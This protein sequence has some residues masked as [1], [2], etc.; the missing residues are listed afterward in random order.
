MAVLAMGAGAYAG[1][2]QGSFCH[3][4]I[5]NAVTTDV[6]HETFRA[7]ETALITVSGDGDTDLDLY[8]YDEN[9]Y[10][11]ASD[12]DLTDQCVVSFTPLWTGSFTIK[13]RNLGSVWNA[14][15]VCM[16]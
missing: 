14:Y 11:I 13:V 9:G 6:Y 2:R 15:T 5:V 4:D 1:P 10:L 12:T 16:F 7:G 3:D 8:V